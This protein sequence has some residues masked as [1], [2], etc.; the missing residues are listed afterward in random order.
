MTDT[1]ASAPGQ[2]TAQTAGPASGGAG[3]R[4]LRGARNY[5][6]LIPFHA[7][8]ALFLILPTAHRRRRRVHDRRAVSRRL[9]NVGAAIHGRD[10]RRRVH[11]V[12]PA[13]REHGH[14]RGDH[15]RSPRLGGRSRGDPN[16]PL[17]Q[18]VD[19]G[20]RR[21]RP[22]RR[23]HARLRLP[24]HVRVQRSG[25]AVLPRRLPRR[26][27]HGRVL[28]VQPDGPGRRLHVLPDPADADRLPAVA[29]WAPPG[30]V[31]RVGEPRRHVVVVLAARRR[32]DPRARASS[33]PCCCCSPTRSPPTRPPPPSSA[34]APRSSPSRSR[35]RFRAKSSSA[36]RTSARRWRS[37]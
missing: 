8:I 33:V 20:V 36:R 3:S 1:S 34:R 15:R 6:A 23:R 32:S 24:C 28:A 22:V 25:D 7:Y 14:R 37:G 29:R 5:L 31:R 4:R 17:R 35:I 13:R 18:L 10:V 11:Q 9:D 16:G 21:A 19:R 26:R 30:V 2:P 27:P 12:D